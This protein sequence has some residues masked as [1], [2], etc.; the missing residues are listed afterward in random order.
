MTERTNVLYD[1]WAK[2]GNLFGPALR[3]TFSQ[4]ILNY[5]KQHINFEFLFFQLTVIWMQKW[6]VGKEQLI[7]QYKQTIM[8]NVNVALVITRQ[9][10]YIHVWLVCTGD[11]EK[12]YFRGFKFSVQLQLYSYVPFLDIFHSFLNWRWFNLM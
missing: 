6:H 7:A 5:A 11:L 8:C 10:I 1:H 3:K 9:M 12:L 2:P 4:K